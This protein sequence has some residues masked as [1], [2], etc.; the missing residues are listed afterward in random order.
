MGENS[1]KGFNLKRKIY[2]SEQ[3][4]FNENHKLYLKFLSI[5]DTNVVYHE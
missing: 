3:N 2:Y 1:L 5:E 4:L